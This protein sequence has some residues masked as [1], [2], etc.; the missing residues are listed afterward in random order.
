MKGVL[1]GRALEGVLAALNA[2]E[3]GAGMGGDFTAGDDRNIEAALNMLRELPNDAVLVACTRAEA[4]A[5]L[6]A[7]GNTFAD[8]DFAKQNMTAEQRRAA[9]AL[10]T[11]LRAVAKAVPQ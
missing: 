6:W 3:A 11:R 8:P 10:R 2:A 9:Y 7:V 1:Q 5:L 4:L